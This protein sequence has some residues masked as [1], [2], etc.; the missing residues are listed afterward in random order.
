M[1]AI[2]A[3]AEQAA[4]GELHAL[5]A[6]GALGLRLLALQPLL[7]AALLFL[8]PARHGRWRL[9]KAL[10]RLAGAG[11]PGSAGRGFQHSS[12]K[13]AISSV[14]RSGATRSSTIELASSRRRVG[15]LLGE[16]AGVRERVHRVAAVADH[17]RR[18]LAC[19]GAR[20]GAARCGRRTG[21]GARRRP[22]PGPGARCRR[23]CRPPTAAA[24]PASRPAW[25]AR[26]SGS[27]KLSAT[28]SGVKAS[29]QA[30]SAPSSTG[31]SITMPRSRS[32]A[33][34]GRLERGVGAQRRAE[35]DR[36]L[37]LEVVEQ[38]DHLLAEEG[39]RVALR[40]ERALR[41]RRGRAGRA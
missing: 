8:L 22:A 14:S 17:E 41:A 38:R 35:H 12:M 7:A 5:A 10:A 26:I 34:D 36:L 15:Q 2:A 39:H 40:V 27:P 11:P 28:I 9:A 20:C 32:G 24:A 13:S 3:T 37:D 33:S 21:P 29:A 1:P 25:T 4:E 23:G 18:R 19:G 6:C 31:I 16:H 30:S